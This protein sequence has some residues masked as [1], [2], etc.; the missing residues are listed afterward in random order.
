MQKLFLPRVKGGAFLLLDLEGWGRGAN[1]STLATVLCVI[2]V[3]KK[4]NL[5][6]NSKIYKGKH[7]RFPHLA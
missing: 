6:F 7:F 1:S 3:L 2:K 4:L 5:L